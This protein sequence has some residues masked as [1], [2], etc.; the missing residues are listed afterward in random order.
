MFRL[1]IHQMVTIYSQNPTKFTMEFDHSPPHGFKQRNILNTE[2]IMFNTD[3]LSTVNVSSNVYE[4]I[5]TG[6]AGSFQF[7]H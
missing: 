1:V 3:V 4:S 6:K 7:V 5:V 2:K